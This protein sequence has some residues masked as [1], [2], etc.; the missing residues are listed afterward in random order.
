MGLVLLLLG[1][2]MTGSVRAQTPGSGRVRVQITQPGP[3]TSVT[4]SEVR[5][6]LATAGDVVAAPPQQSAWTAGGQ[7]HVYLDG[8]DV[9]Q[10][11][12]LQFSIQPVATGAHTLRVALQEW[13]GGQA[14]PA[15]AAFTVAAAPTPAGASWWLSGLVAVVGVG[16]LVGL[17]FFWL[18][19]VRPMQARP[20]DPTQAAERLEQIDRE[21]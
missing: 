15:E 9:L 7:F 19:W 1:L 20:A 13:P 3:G 6:A 10:T 5:V 21:R 18:R 16:L 17:L 8:T 11:T 14:V 4:G 12:L 2:I